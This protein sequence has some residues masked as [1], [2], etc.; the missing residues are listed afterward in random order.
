MLGGKYFIFLLFAIAQVAE[1]VDALDSK[2]SDFGRV[3]SIPTLSTVKNRNDLI[4]WALRFF[5][6]FISHYLVINLIADSILWSAV[7]NKRLKQAFA[8]AKSGLMYD[9]KYKSTLVKN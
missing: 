9:G 4:L 2:S 3:G 5:I 6:I 8:I 7:C 1:L